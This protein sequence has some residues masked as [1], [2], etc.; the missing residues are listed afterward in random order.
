[1]RHPV[2]A[3]C[4]LIVGML[5]LFGGAGCRKNE[6]KVVEEKTFNVQLKTAEK[7][8]LRPFIE[9]IGTLNANEEVTVSAQV[10]G[11]LNSVK[12]DEGVVVLKG[13]PIIFIDDTD[14]GHEVKRDEAALKQA[15]ATLANTKIEMKRKEALY[16][17]ELVTQQQFDDVSTRLSL[18]EAEVDRLRALLSL[19]KLKLAKT[20]IVAP[21]SGV[22]KERKVSAGDF[23]KNGTPLC[24]VIQ[25]NPIK[26][27]FSVPEREVSKLR[28]G[29]DIAVKVDAY[30]DRDFTGSVSIIY[31]HVE[32]KTRT[33]LVEALVPNGQGLLKPG[34][35]AKVVLYTG[36]ERDIVVI[37]ITAVL[38]EGEGTKVFVSEAD[39]AKMRTVKLGNKYGE[40]MEIIEGV[41]AG[42]K[43]VV[44]GQQN[45]SQGAKLKVASPAQEGREKPA[46][47]KK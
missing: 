10:E 43:V 18:S 20:R 47:N 7:Q 26:L 15:E 23:V 21:I 11:V 14:Y 32:E 45:L 9:A 1:M 39:R 29:Q 6:A 33:L 35:F 27:Q 28:I 4:S 38:Y 24:V 42:D 37:P 13:T 40:M 46:G 44:A 3:G 17:E 22:V 5:L 16:K 19:A 36:G 8:P 30:R 41:N 34:L 12:I 25:S 2:Y 31:P